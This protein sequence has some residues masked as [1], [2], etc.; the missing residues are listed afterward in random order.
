MKYLISLNNKFTNINPK[1]LYDLTKNTADGYEIFLNKAY[2]YKYYLEFIKIAKNKIINFHGNIENF[3]KMVSLIQF[4]SNNL[5]GTN[6][7]IH[8]KI[9]L[10]IN[11]SINKTCKKVDKL[12]K[13]I[14]RTNS[15]ITLSLENLNSVGIIKRLNKEDILPILDNYKNLLFTYDIGHEMVEK[16]KIIDLTSTHIKKLNN[17]HFHTFIDKMDHQLI[18]KIDEK[19]NTA[20]EYL[21]KLKYDSYF[22]FEYDFYKS[23]GNNDLEKLNDFLS[24]MNIVKNHVESLKSNNLRKYR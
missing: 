19:I 11:D 17:V 16:K 2:D 8:P 4:I 9:G 22:V 21:I 14:E 15:N 13:I 1:E 5:S 23:K 12:Q 6:I 24:S 10:S 20:L 7:V 18:Y 3:G